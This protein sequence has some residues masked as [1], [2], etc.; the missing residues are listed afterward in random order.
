MNH[1]VVAAVALITIV[2]IREADV[3]RAIKAAIRLQLIQLH[4]VKT[5]RAFEIAFTTFRAEAARKVTDAIGIQ[6]AEFVTDFAVE[7]ER[8]FF[9]EDLDIDRGAK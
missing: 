1:Q 4:V 6:Q 8:A 9:L 7:F 5:F 3:D 2:L